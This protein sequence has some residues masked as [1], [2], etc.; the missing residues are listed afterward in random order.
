MQPY[1]TLTQATH[2][3]VIS[4][5]DEMKAVDVTSLDVRGKTTITDAI[6]ICNGNSI[7]H[8]RSIAQHLVTQAKAR[9]LKVIGVE[10]E[11]S[12]DW[13][14]IDLGDVV[15]HVMLPAT[16]VFYQLEKLWKVDQGA[17]RYTEFSTVTPPI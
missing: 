8:A 7:R 6:V 12:G 13:I 17:G 4:A 14:L 16:R 1:E 15:T 10:G 3:Y 9:G 11:D 2:S 5:L